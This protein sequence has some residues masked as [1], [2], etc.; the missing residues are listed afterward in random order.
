MK[1]LTNR[2][3]VISFDCL[4]SSDYQLIRTL[5]NFRRVLNEG[6]YVQHVEAIYPSLTY[7]SHVSIVTGN[8]PKRHG[9]INNTLLQP[10]ASSPDWNWYRANIKGTTLYDEAYKANLT[11]A[12]L[13]WPVTGKAKSIQYNLPE[14]FANRPWHNQIAVSLLNG[15]PAFLWDLNKRF[16]HIRNG[17]NQ[18][19]LDDFV[20][21]CTIYTLQTKKPDLLL[22]H[23]TDLDTNRHQNGV[24]SSEAT[25]AIHRHD[26]RLGRIL[27]DLEER[28]ELAETTI[29]VL[30]D[31]SA[32]DE[33]KAISPNVIL[34]EENLI[35]VNRKGKITDWKAYC[36]SCDGSAYIYLKHPVDTQTM[37][38]VKDI[39]TKLA[40]DP[41]KG[42]EYVLTGEE[43]GEK[44]L[45]PNVLL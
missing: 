39:L 23:F 15:T 9:V 30:G 16:G 6:S 7:P 22:I 38:T 31:H 17:L 42:I 37:K 26:K 4:S 5:P 24:F 40:A 29:V 18:P 43:A 14:I 27:D 35:T 28:G 33:N 34:Y 19:E 45:I 1:A 3:I 25:E 2:L 36:K 12:A 20:L 10:G 21:E 11:T 13:L 44:A 8:Y 41:S 32:L